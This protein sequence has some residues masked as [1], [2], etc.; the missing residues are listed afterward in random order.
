MLKIKG[1]NLLVILSMLLL[2]GAAV[3]TIYETSSIADQTKPDSIYQIS[4]F[5]A[6]NQGALGSIIPAIDLK[7]HGDLGIGTFEGV[8]GEMIVV[9]GVIYQ[10]TTTGVNVIRDGDSTTTPFAQVTFFHP[11]FSVAVRNASNDSQFGEMVDQSLPSNNTFFAIRIDG[12]FPHVQTRVIPPQH[13]PYPTYDEALKQAKYVDL[14]NVTG[15]IVGYYS[16]AYSENFSVP[17]YHLHFISA[18]KTE[19]GHITDF[20]IDQSTVWLDPTPELEVNLNTGSKFYGPST[21]EAA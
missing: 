21:G 2:I 5:Y 1:I 3:I 19:G 7:N 11:V 18:N 8:D 12:T 13:K 14:Y 9:D 20:A 16:P 6:I 4:T 10:A 15:T 17:G